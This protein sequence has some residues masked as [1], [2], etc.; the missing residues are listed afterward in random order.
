[1]KALLNPLLLFVLFGNAQSISI[2]NSQLGIIQTSK[3][4]GTGFAFMG[5]NLVF[6]AAH[7][8]FNTKNIEYDAFY[9]RGNR[10]L[11]PNFKKLRILMIDTVYDFAILRSKD[12]ITVDYFKLALRSNVCTGDFVF[13]I[14]FDTAMTIKTGIPA[15][16]VRCS[17]ITKVDS[18]WN[19]KKLVK[20]FEFLG[21]GVPGYS[22]GPVINSDGQIV[23]FMKA[24]RK[25]NG[26]IIDVAYNIAP[27]LRKYNF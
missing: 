26:Q 4:S 22:G 21:D 8:V 6:T 13:Y 9:V 25:E 17:H 20:L 14:G 11:A 15:L 27:N 18:F 24:Y 19:G 5:K 16:V 10:A 23:G 3:G 1:M 7:V 12:S 2:H